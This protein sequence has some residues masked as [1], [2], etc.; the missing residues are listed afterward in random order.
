MLGVT[1]DRDTSLL[2][3]FVLEG[4]SV[5]SRDI[6]IECIVTSYCL[7]FNRLSLLSH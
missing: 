3:L 1:K 5:E 6:I 7:W 2:L 4:D